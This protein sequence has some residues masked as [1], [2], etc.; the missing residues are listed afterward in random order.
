MSI[1]I[2]KCMLIISILGRLEVYN[3]WIIDTEVHWDHFRAVDL[4]LSGSNPVIVG[5][6]EDQTSS[7]PDRAFTMREYSL[8]GSATEVWAFDYYD[9]DYGCLDEDGYGIVKY[10][11][12]GGTPVDHFIGVGFSRVDLL[13]EP[14]N[15]EDCEGLAILLDDDGDTECA[16]YLFSETWYDVCCRDVVY[17]GHLDGQSHAYATCGWYDLTDGSTENLRGFLEIAYGNTEIDL[18]Q[19]SGIA[20]MWEKITYDSEEDLIVMGGMCEDASRSNLDNLRLGCVDLSGSSPYQID[21]Q[22][23]WGVGDYLYTEGPLLLIDDGLYV[24]LGNAIDGSVRGVAA[25]FWSWD[26]DSESITREDEETY[27]NES[28][29]EFEDYVSLGVFAATTRSTLIDD[30]IILLLNAVDRTNSDPHILIAHIIYYPA[31][32]TFGNITLDHEFEITPQSGYT[33]SAGS[34][35]FTDRDPVQGIGAGGALGSSDQKIWLFEIVDE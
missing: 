17:V 22:D 26:S 15:N 6:I 24:Y 13:N 7:D 12:G 35:V 28:G 8:N 33:V 16:P 27:T 1:M 9:P 14:P 18:I 25:T 21:D 10:E 29:E 2:L 4:V 19:D 11:T 30:R 34:F 5:Y 31:S 3:Y 20:G 32:K 23:D